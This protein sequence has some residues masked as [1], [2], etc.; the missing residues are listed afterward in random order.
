MPS[1]RRARF[2][3]GL[4]AGGGSIPYQ[5]F[6]PWGG[7][8]P[9]QTGTNT[10][11]AARSCSI[12]PTYADRDYSGA[13][14]LVGTGDQSIGRGDV[15]GA[16]TDDLWLRVGKWRSWDLQAGR[17]EGWEVFHLGMG[18][19]FNTFERSG[20]VGQSAAVYQISFYGV[21]DNEFRPQGPAGDLAF[22]YYPLPY[23][24]FELLGSAGSIGQNPMYAARPVAIFDIGWLKLKFGSEY[25]N[26]RGL[27]R[28]IRP[29]S[30]QRES[31]ARC[32]SSSIPTSSSAQRRPGHDPGHRQQRPRQPDRQPHAHQR[33]RLAN[34]SNGDP[35]HTVLF[36]VGSMLTWTEDQNG[37][38]PNPIDK[39]WLYQ[40]FIAAQYVLHNAFYIKLVGGYSAAHFSLGGDDPRIV[41]DNEMYSARLRFSFYF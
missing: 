11:A 39:Y 37:I 3:L 7:P 32:S 9:E 34:I 41:Y 38:E 27:R 8:E 31:A 30:P 14:E 15:G 21:T 10:E 40:G 22:H 4:Q 5:K 23:L 24:R 13:G 20:A 25:Q 1:P 28:R 36:G 18:L 35:R 2:V 12:T 26:K 16:D 29:T 6:Q 17:F 33:R 19:D